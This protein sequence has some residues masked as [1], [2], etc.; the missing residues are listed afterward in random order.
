[1]IGQYIQKCGVKNKM[2]YLGSSDDMPNDQMRYDLLTQDAM[3]SV[4]R[5]A[6]TRVQKDGL[7]GEH[8]FF[9]TFVTTAPGVEIS[10]VL[11][12]RYPQEMTIVLQ[13][14]FWG[15]DVEENKFAV[16]LTFNKIPEKL[17]VPFAAIK[18]FF[19][20]SVQFG[21]QFPIEG[22]TALDFELPLDAEAPDLERDVAE[23]DVGDEA[24]GEVVSL[25]TFRKK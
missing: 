12:G 8:H 22:Q 17:V 13:H 3:R 15:L 11:I 23:A 9:I 5:G 6:L 4:V 25:D 10:D 19:D 14:Q 20:P 21:L 2:D 7:P 24:P 16:G 18:G 1:L